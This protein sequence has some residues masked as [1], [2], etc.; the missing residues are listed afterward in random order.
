PVSHLSLL[1]YFSS[2]APATP[3]FYTLSLHDALPI[4]ASPT[5]SFFRTS[6]LKP[7]TTGTFRESFT[8]KFSTFNTVFP[9]CFGDFSFLKLTERP[10]INAASSSTVV[11]L[12]SNL[13]LPT[14]F[15]ITVH[16]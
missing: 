16:R 5:I 15:R 3:E 8:C 13:L 11:S 7:F 4:S 2:H 9:G 6:R 14:P 1:S 12:T 10:T